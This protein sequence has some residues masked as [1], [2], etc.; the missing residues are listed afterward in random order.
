MKTNEVLKQ[1]KRI[2]KKNG[3]YPT[4]EEQERYYSEQTKD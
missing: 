4:L 3:Y 2:A 1:A